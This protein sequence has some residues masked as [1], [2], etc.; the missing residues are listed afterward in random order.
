MAIFEENQKGYPFDFIQNNQNLQFLKKSKGVLLL[1]LSKKWPILKKLIISFPYHFIQILLIL[2]KIERIFFLISFKNC[3]FSMK[4]KEDHLLIFSNIAH[5]DFLFRIKRVN[6]NPKTP[7][8]TQHLTYSGIKT[9]R[10][11]FE[12]ENLGISRR[13][14]LENFEA[15]RRSPQEISGIW[16]RRSS[17]SIYKISGSKTSE[18]NELNS[19]NSI[20]AVL[21]MQWPLRL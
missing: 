12:A 15:W 16:W 9:P 2:D 18:K 13:S 17:S 10:K 4:F 6:S 14:M 19:F 20:V 11:I 8:I 3:H 1:I 5:F 7:K 21:V